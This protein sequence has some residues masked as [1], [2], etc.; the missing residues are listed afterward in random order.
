MFVEANP[1]NKFPLH[2][3]INY[4]I[5]ISASLQLIRAGKTP[6]DSHNLIHRPTPT[7]C[8]E[9]L[10]PAVFTTLFRLQY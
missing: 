1:S 6:T 8:L 4:F 3:K 5:S 10:Y 2:D 7:P 9:Y